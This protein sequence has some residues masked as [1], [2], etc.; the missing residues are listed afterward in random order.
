MALTSGSESPQPPRDS[1]AQV[2]NPRG[3]RAAATWAPEAD[4]PQFTMS[5]ITTLANARN[6]G[7]EIDFSSRDSV[8]TLAL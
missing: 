8:Q 7:T 2:G 1:G 5:V 4:E 3:L 6:M